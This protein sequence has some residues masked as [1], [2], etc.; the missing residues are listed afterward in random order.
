MGRSIA[1]HPRGE[2]SLAGRR[3]RRGTEGIKR[4]AGPRGCPSSCPAEALGL[5]ARRRRIAETRDADEAIPL[6]LGHLV[7][8]GRARDAAEQFEPVGHLV[9]E[10]PADAEIERG[11]GVVRMVNPDAVEG[12]GRRGV[13]AP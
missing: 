3:R 13:V 1:L 2:G 5:G 6:G 9:L 10:Q 7:R 12:R 11:G 4:G 8:R